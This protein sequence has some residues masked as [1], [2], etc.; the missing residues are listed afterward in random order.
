[1]S[2]STLL[3]KIKPPI[4]FAS[5]D[6]GS[7]FSG[8]A[9]AIRQDLENILYKPHGKAYCK[10]PTAVLYDAQSGVYKEFGWTALEKFNKNQDK[11]ARYFKLFL[12][13][14]KPT[15]PPNDFP[16]GVSP[17]KVIVTFL[18]KISQQAIED[19]RNTYYG[20]G[21]EIVKEEDIQ[22]C[23]TV[24]A[25]WNES[26][27][28]IMRAAATQAGMIIGEGCPA[29]RGSPHPLEIV[30]EPEAASV[31]AITHCNPELQT[32]DR[33]LVVDNGAG[34]C[35]I[36]AHELLEGGG[37]REICKGD[38]APVGGASVD[39]NFLKYLRKRF[40]NFSKFEEENPNEIV[41][42]MQMFEEKKQMFRAVEEKDDEQG[43]M[44]EPKHRFCKEVLDDDDSFMIEYEDMRGMYDPVVETIT[45]EVDQFINQC[46]DIK[47]IV[48][49]G[50][51]ST[52][53]YLT[54][55]F[56]ERYE[57][58]GKVEEVIKPDNPGAAVMM[59]AVL[60]AENP[61]IISGRYSRKTYGVEICREFRANTVYPEGTKIEHI[62]GVKY[63]CGCFDVFARNGE[64]VE[65]DAKVTRT[66][67]PLSED[68]TQM[69]LRIYCTDD[70]DPQ[71]VTGN[72]ETHRMVKL[73]PG[74]DSSVECSFYFGRSEVQV[75][76][77]NLKTNEE[78]E[79]SFV[80]LQNKSPLKK[81]S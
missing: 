60:Y 70:P 33:I 74:T 52:S 36:V 13:P 6:F 37:V 38:G 5:L 62:D 67:V 63:V 79:T 23:I 54:Q 7:G 81:A 51:F 31:Y 11:L 40:D 20:V 73:E 76:C 12:S 44:I 78:T 14:T 58:S 28:N 75:K 64:Q 57:K 29:G 72:P 53:E 3:P 4:F 17:F 21:D 59:G 77:K 48:M 43:I 15:H 47:Y 39:N 80:F 2:M 42:L 41:S 32:G 16:T 71:F 61:S 46:K 22:W 25:I 9:F 66:Y 27:K 55:R 56:K 69:N 34:T 8:V 24:P 49:V 35:D 26:S 45:D 19:I 68:Q 65:F 30:L 18:E 50:G 1:M 10:G